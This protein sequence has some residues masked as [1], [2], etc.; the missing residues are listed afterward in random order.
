MFD[1]FKQVKQMRDLQQQMKK[2]TYEAERDGVRIVVDGTFNVQE[3]HLNPDKS[4]TDQ[5]HAV[6]ECFN[7]AIKKAQYGAAQRLQG[8]M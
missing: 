4:A 1:K 2:E 3:V 8:M 6:Q 5:E 7:D